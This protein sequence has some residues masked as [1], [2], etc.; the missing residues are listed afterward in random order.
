MQLAADKHICL[1]FKVLTPSPLQPSPQLK[2]IYANPVVTTLSLS[3]V[4]TE[5][6][7][8][9]LSDQVLIVG[10]WSLSSWD[11]QHILFTKV[12]K[13]RAK[14]CAPN[15]VRGWR[16]RWRKR[17]FVIYYGSDH[18]DFTS[19][20]LIAQSGGLVD[21]RAAPCWHDPKPG[22]FLFA[23][24]FIGQFFICNFFQFFVLTWPKTCSC[25][26]LSASASANPVFTFYGL[27]KFYIK[28]SCV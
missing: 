2:M 19:V 18:T 11:Q 13:V 25:S 1:P 6:H 12:T 10:Q 28:A 26:T 8:G 3:F 16:P 21:L 14:N 17:W 9:N 22:P 20:P 5:S 4:T 23:I 7:S 27:F 15:K 24:C